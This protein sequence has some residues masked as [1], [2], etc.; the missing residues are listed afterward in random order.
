MSSGLDMSEVAALAAALAAAPAKVMPA[1]IPVA[2]KAGVNIKRV[3]KADASGHRYLPGLSRAVEYEL[4]ATPSSVS[5]EVGFAKRGQGNLAAIAA[6][7]TPRTAPVMD[8]TR[9]LTAETPRFAD[10]LVRV[11]GEALR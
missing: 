4:S 6:F 2:S 8:I 1:V 5:V 11:A 10:W 3:M 9:G 7:G